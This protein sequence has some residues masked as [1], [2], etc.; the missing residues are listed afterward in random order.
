M[1]RVPRVRSK[2]PRDVDDI[3]EIVLYT[4]QDGS[5]KTTDAWTCED[6]V[7]IYQKNRA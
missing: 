6:D 1:G 5:L 3:T 7:R 4:E 2:Q